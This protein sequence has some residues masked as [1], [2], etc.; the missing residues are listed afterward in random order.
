MTGSGNDA[1]GHRLGRHDGHEFR[2]GSDVEPSD[3][4]TGLGGIGVEQCRN[5]KAPGTEA[6]VRGQCATEV[7]DPH[8]DHRPVL[9]E[10]ELASDLMQQV[11]HVV[12][13][14]TSAVR[15]Q[16]TEVLTYLGGIDARD[17]G[18]RHR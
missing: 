11:L 3:L 13:H 12:A 10:A 8:N 16:I 6:A 14:S 2:C 15:A 4:G 18:Q 7:A 5:P 1:D 17:F 9:G